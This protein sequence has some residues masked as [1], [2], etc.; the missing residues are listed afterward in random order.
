MPLGL[1][2]QTTREVAAG[3]ELRVD[4]GRKYWERRGFSQNDPRRLAIDYLL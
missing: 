3:E 1:W 2:V 4:Y